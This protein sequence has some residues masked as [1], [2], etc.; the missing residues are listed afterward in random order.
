M[1]GVIQQEWLNQNALRA[2]PFSENSQRRPSSDSGL[3]PTAFALPNSFIL[4]L[5]ISV[6]DK[7]TASSGIY[8]SR[9]TLTGGFATV[10]LSATSNSD[11]VASITVDLSKHSNYGSY[12]FSGVNAYSD[13]RGCIVLGDPK[14]FDDY[15]DG[16]YSFLPEETTFEAR[17]LRPDIAGVRSIGVAN[18]ENTYSTKGLQGDVKLIAGSNIRLR[19]SATEN[20]IWI[21]ADYNAGYNEPCDCG[22][23]G[24]GDGECAGVKTINGIAV[25]DVVIEGGDCISVETKEGVISISDTCSKPCAGC[26]ELNLL[27]SKTNGLL[28]AV[29]ALSGYA[30]LLSMRISQ[31]ELSKASWKSGSVKNA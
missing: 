20:A 18:A 21:D 13:M 27:S 14:A 9:F 25:D 11:V 1:P 19:Y 28:S 8:M 31:F 5:I 30:D 6:P 3:M 16:I 22:G 29:S 7:T 4:D 12:R 26:E 17:C 15:P 2:Y 23:G 10:V 24:S